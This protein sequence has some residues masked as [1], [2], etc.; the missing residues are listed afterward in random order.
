MKDK[1]YIWEA[2]KEV[3]KEYFNSFAEAK[4][5]ATEIIKAGCDSLMILECVAVAV[6]QRITVVDDNFPKVGV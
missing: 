2:D 6:A 3:K 5:A 4:I 1:Y